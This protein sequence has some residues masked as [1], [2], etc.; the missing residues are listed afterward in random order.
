MDEIEEL[1]I[2]Y[3]KAVFGLFTHF[4]DYLDSKLL[5][6]G[7]ILTVFIEKILSN[8]EDR[9]VTLSENECWN[10]IVEKNEEDPR[11]IAFMAVL[12]KETFSPYGVLDWYVYVKFW[13]FL[14]ERFYDFEKVKDT[15]EECLKW[16]MIPK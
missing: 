9:M 7:N 4:T 15:F 10:L 5:K 8:P 3:I 14:E 12:F 11:I 16:M 2:E 6:E 13:M 1:G